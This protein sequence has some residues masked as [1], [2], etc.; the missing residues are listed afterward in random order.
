MLRHGLS[1]HP[2]FRCQVGLD[3]AGKTTTLYKL[4]LGQ[5]ISTQP[6]VGSNVEQVTYK[7][8]QF[9]VSSLPPQPPSDP[10]GSTLPCCLY[11]AR[12]DVCCERGRKWGEE[13]DSAGMDPHRP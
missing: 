6:T 8:L 5:V 3:N 11:V 1:S 10:P 13:L 9:E 12:G 2:R 7:N 4:H